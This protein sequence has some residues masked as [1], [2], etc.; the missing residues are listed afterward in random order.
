MCI[1]NE[2]ALRVRAAKQHGIIEN[3]RK[4]RRRRSIAPLRKGK[5]AIA[6][7]DE[8]TAHRRTLPL[9]LAAQVLG[10]RRL[11]VI[12][13][14]ECGDRDTVQIGKGETGEH[15]MPVHIGKGFGHGFAG[16]GN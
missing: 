3:R 14:A 9:A 7:R 16:G 4:Q 8:K 13:A 2:A 11:A 10:K 12:V 1:R 6:Q 5:K 15:E